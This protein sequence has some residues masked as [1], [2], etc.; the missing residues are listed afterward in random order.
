M[1]LGPTNDDREAMPPEDRIM[2]ALVTEIAESGLAGLS[3]DRVASRAAVSKTTIYSRWRTKDDLVVAAFASLASGPIEFKLDRGLRHALRGMFEF[4]KRFVTDPRME[5]LL[6]ELFAASHSNDAVRELV[7]EFRAT[8]YRATTTMFARARELGEL[9]VDTDVE[10]LSEVVAA[11]MTYRAVSPIFDDPFDD[12]T[13]RRIESLVLATPP[14][15][16][17]TD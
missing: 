3:I 2:D 13:L 16:V 11:L 6:A 12:V 4:G 1:Q 5:A 17:P 8:W 14:R 10:F 9:P 7:A 15:L